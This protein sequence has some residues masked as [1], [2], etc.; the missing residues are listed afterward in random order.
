MY[1]RYVE[2]NDRRDSDVDSNSEDFV[3]LDVSRL[4]LAYAYGPK[5]TETLIEA[6]FNP[7][8]L[9]VS[10]KPEGKLNPFVQ[11]VPDP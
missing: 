5:T 3:P 1:G 8:Q 2:E 9:P 7:V 11:Y 6:L 10:L 4:P